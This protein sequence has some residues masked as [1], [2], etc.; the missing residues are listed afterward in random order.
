MIQSIL[1]DHYPKRKGH[2]ERAIDIAAIRFD[3]D[4]HRLSH[5]ASFKRR[6]VSPP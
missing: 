2:R 6:R 5:H 3:V 1:R 4:R